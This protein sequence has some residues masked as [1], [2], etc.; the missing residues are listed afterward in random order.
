VLQITDLGPRVLGIAMHA[1]DAAMNWIGLMM[2][3][4]AAGATVKMNIITDSAGDN[5]TDQSQTRR[6]EEILACQLA[7]ITAVEFL[8]GYPDGHADKHKA[9]IVKDLAKIIREFDPTAVVTFDRRHGL[10]GHVDHREG[11]DCVWQALIAA[12]SP[13]QLL[14][15]ALTEQWHDEVMPVLDQLA[16]AIYHDVPLDA[17]PDSQLDLVLKLSAEE[18]DTKTKAVLAHDSQIWP[19]INQ[20]AKVGGLDFLVSKWFAREAFTVS[21]PWEPPSPLL[22]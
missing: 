10:T 16:K 18:L 15:T 1:D 7:G 8:H 3:A 2:R 5:G 6:Q 9:Q 20:L 4:I 17:T 12:Q 11:A 19:L 14:Q 21:R 22:S 13:A